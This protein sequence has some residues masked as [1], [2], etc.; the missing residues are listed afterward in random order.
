MPRHNGNAT[1]NTT[2]PA[3]RSLG[4]EFQPDTGA[5]DVGEV[6]LVSDIEDSKYR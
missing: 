1:R 6:A 2:K 4:S 5:E 3:A